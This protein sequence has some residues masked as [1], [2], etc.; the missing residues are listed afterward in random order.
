MLDWLLDRGH[1]LVLSHYWPTR[2][3]L[4]AGCRPWPDAPFVRQPGHNRVLCCVH[5]DAS[6]SADTGSTWTSA[7]QD[8]NPQA[9]HQLWPPG[10]WITRVCQYPR[11]KKHD[12]LLYINLGV[13]RI[14]EYC[15]K[16][17]NLCLGPYHVEST[18][19]RPITEVK[20]RWVV[21]VLGWVTAWEYTMS[22]TFCLFENVAPDLSYRVEKQR[23][24]EE[25]WSFIYKKSLVCIVFLSTA[26]N[27]IK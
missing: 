27:S 16:P 25:V 24:F 20:Q 3:F 12:I 14:I 22:Q 4:D 7:Q 23:I 18:S 5:V 9:F 11:S 6:L 17:L 10:S 13:Y 8:S 19:S 26:L 2:G 21:L 1:S 15:I